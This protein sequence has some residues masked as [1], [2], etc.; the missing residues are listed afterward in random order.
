MLNGG[1]SVAWHGA[2]QLVGNLVEYPHQYYVNS[3]AVTASLVSGESVEADAM[4]GNEREM[5]LIYNRLKPQVGAY[6]T[7]TMVS[8]SALQPRLQTDLVW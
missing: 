4:T 6:S 7:E 2:S 3:I 8:A 5:L 1:R